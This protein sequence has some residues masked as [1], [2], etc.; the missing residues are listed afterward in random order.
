MN[1]LINILII[2][3][4]SLFEGNAQCWKQLAGGSYFSAAIKVD[5]S[6]WSWGIN[7]NGE[8]GDGTNIGKLTPNQIGID[9]NWRS[10]SCG[11]AHNVAIKN[12][13]TLWGWGHN[14]Y[15]QL[16]NGANINLNIPT[17]NRH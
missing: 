12:D 8:L 3:C 11:T 6:L 5:G 7:L 14:L 9:N 10:I 13:S 15:G 2:V 17:K 16:G 4:I 1:K